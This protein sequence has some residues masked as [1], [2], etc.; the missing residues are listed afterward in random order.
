MF[1]RGLGSK[2]RVVKGVVGGAKVMDDG[3]GGLGKVMAGVVGD[4]GLG[5]V[6]TGELL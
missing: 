5:L 1:G 3:G 4:Y 2:K 6:A